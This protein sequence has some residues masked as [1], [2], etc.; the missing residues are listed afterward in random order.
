[1]LK[2]AERNNDT[3]LSP[4]RCFWDTWQR[5]YDTREMLTWHISGSTTHPIPKR[6]VRLR[7]NVWPCCH[8]LMSA[9]PADAHR[10]DCWAVYVQRQLQHQFHHLLV[11][12]ISIQSKHAR[13]YFLV[14]LD[15]RVLHKQKTQNRSKAVFLLSHFLTVSETD[16]V[17]STSSPTITFP[18]CEFVINQRHNTVPE[19]W[20]CFPGCVK[21]AGCTRGVWAE[22]DP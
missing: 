12:G 10:A 4:T 17:C 19:G 8:I 22:A 20:P 3:A 6:P 18:G 21:L 15:R 13:K 14:S 7:Q 2:P 16:C 1:M 11:E 9:T 5:S